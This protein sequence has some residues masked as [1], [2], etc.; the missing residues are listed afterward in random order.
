MCASSVRCV[1]D[2]PIGAARPCSTFLEL[3]IIASG[4][5]LEDAEEDARIAEGE[6][7]AAAEEDATSSHVLRL[8]FEFKGGP[9]T[10]IIYT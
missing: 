4:P 9:R 2:H 10:I 1:S 7:A 8:V 5:P 3:A 6:D